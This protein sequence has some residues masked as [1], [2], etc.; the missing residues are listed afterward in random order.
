MIIINKV[1][2][3]GRLSKDVELR[4][5]PGNGTPVASINLA[6]DNYNSK[7]GEKGADF[8]PVVIWGKTAENL[9]QYLVKGTQVAIAGKIST[10]SYE[11][12]DG[13]KRYVTEVIADMYQGVKLL[14]GKKSAF[15]DKSSHDTFQDM[16]NTF[17]D[18]L[19]IDDSMDN[20]PF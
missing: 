11:A 14:G 15:G 17:G 3:V 10:R 12:K 4:Y 19:E 18:D 7:T 6:V 20:M 13:T 5:T 16:V 1:V 2:L 9:S 8:I